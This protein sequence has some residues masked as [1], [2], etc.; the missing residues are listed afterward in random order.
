MR[1]FIRGCGIS[2]MLGGALTLLINAL[3]TPFVPLNQTADVMVTNIFLVRQCA[4]GFAAFFL[5]AGSIGLHLAQ[6]PQSGWFGS[7]AFVVAFIGGGLLIAV[8]FADTFVLRALAQIAPQTAD[9]LDKSRLLNTGFALA[10]GFFAAGWLLMSVTAWKTRLLP[11]WAA[12]ATLA[13][14]F[15][16]SILQ[17]AFGVFGAVIGNAVFGVG[18][19]G[20][21]WALASGSYSVEKPFDFGSLTKSG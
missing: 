8:E 10:I 12:S 14:L 4:S 7:L 16:I 15:L 2:L 21:G 13:G 17:A 5:L 1:A 9:A 19:I 18:L 6:R 20:L 3:I 11:R